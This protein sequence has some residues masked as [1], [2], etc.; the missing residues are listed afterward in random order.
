MKKSA[1]GSK[2]KRSAAP[3]AAAKRRTPTRGAAGRAAAPAAPPAP[4]AAEGHY[5]PPP[6]R[7][8]GWAPF[9]YPPQ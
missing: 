5:T 6:L 1:K 8:D 3:K 7:T 9:R 2:S 4:R